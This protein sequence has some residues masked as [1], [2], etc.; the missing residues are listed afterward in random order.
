VK[1]SEKKI[2][3]MLDM[4]FIIKTRLSQIE[5]GLLINFNIGTTIINPADIKA[6]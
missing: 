1:Y 2:K 6:E 4:R 5:V 3:Y